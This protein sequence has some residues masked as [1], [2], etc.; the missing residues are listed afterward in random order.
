MCTAGGPRFNLHCFSTWELSHTIAV[1]Q[2]QQFAGCQECSQSSSDL[3][4]SLSSASPA[5][6]VRGG[7]PRGGWINLLGSSHTGHTVQW[8]FILFF[9]VPVK[10]FFVQIL[11]VTEQGLWHAEVQPSLPTGNSFPRIHVT[12]NCCPEATAIYFCFTQDSPSYFL[13]SS[14]F[15]WVIRVALRLS[16]FWISSATSQ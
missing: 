11:E 1:Q 8:I 13:F 16:L 15:L 2:Q 7:L 6:E 10:N 12:R 3:G 9:C 14:A 4:L 5:R